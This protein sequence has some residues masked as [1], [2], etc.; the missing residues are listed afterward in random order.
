MTGLDISGRNALVTGGSRGIGRAV[1]LGLARAGVNVVTCY[2]SGGEPVESLARAL[3]ETPGDHHL[4]R[5]DVSDAEQV[6]HLVRECRTRLGGLHVVVNNAGVIS[7]VP[8]AELPL[9]EWHRV[10]NNS[11]TAAH[12]VTQRAL[13]LL[14]DGASII[15]IGSRVSTVGVPLR[16]HY[17]AAKAGLVGLSR[18]LARELGGR[19]I[20]VNVVEPGV[21]ET[22]EA[23]KLSPEEYARAQARYRQLTALGRIGQPDEL[24]DVV[25]FLASDLSR[26]VTGATIHV[27]GGI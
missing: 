11:L 13:P 8:Y 15:N 1:V 12:L 27:D 21:I 26:Y 22:E 24:A 5:A 23:A 17:T 20:R 7:H 25:L 14:G 18:S 6:D 3:K 9:E 2:R 16:S 10:V 4:V 19:G